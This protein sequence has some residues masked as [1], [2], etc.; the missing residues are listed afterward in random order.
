[1]TGTPSPKG[2]FG[3]RSLV[4]S[5]IAIALCEAFFIMDVLADVFYLDIPLIWKINHGVVE[6]ITTGSLAMAL[7]VIGWQ[8]QRLLGEHRK[9]HDSVRVASGELLSVIDDHFTQWRLSPSEREI[10]LLLIKGFS[11]QEIADLRNTR[12]GT[13][14]SQSSAIYQKVGIRGRN[15]LAAYFVEDLLGGDKLLAQKSTPPH[16]ATR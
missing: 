4:F 8:I 16:G 14:K 3:I 15:E 5:F 11:T 2:V 13:V 9:A 10:A 1:M 6:L 7:G 12:C